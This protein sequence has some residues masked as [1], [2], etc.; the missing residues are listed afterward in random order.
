MLLRQVQAR[1]LQGHH[2]RALRRRGDAA[3]GAPRA[4]GSHRPRRSGLA[5]LVLQGR[6]EPHRLPA[7]HRSARARE[8]SLLRGV[9]RHAGRRE[10]RA[11]GSRRPRG[12]GRGRE[13]AR[14]PRPRRG[15]RRARATVCPGAATT[16]RPARRRTSTRTTTSGP[17]ACR[18]GPRRGAP[19]ARGGRAR[20]AAACSSSSRKDH[21]G[22]PR[23]D[24]RAGPQD[25]DPR[26]SPAG[27]SRGGVGRA[28]AVQI[29]AAL[30][31]LRGELGE[32]DRLEEGRDHEAPEEDPGGA[33][34]GRRAVGGRRRAHAGRRAEEPRAARE[35]G[36]A[37]SETCSQPS[38]RTPM[39]RRC[40]SSRTT[41]ASSRARRR[42]TWTRSASGR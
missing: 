8:G 34:L 16:S 14:L 18:T 36:T 4:H 40:A 37:C 9:D 21:V 26:G 1:P 2:L 31:P 35:V 11:E 5:H 13:R 23:R 20:S 25:R 32:R 7:R 27:A 10:K 3:E 24:P 33:A 41:S 15:A 38:T 22:G 19:D 12:Q 28:S 39:R 42:R 29:E 17:A 30:A 6:A